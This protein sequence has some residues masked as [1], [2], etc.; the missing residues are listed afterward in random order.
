MQ[1]SEMDERFL[2]CEKNRAKHNWMVAFVCL[3]KEILAGD[4]CN[5]EGAKVE[6]RINIYNT[7]W[8]TCGEPDQIS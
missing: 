7:E 6:G 3:N 5:K 1:S 8:I 4:G 2:F